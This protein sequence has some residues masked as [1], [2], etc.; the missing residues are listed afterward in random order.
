MGEVADLLVRRKGIRRVLC[1]A[2]VGEDLLF[3]VRTT[4][5][6]ENACQ[7]VVETTDQLGSG[8][9]HDRRAGG[10]IPGVVR[11]GTISQTLEKEI[12]TRWLQACQ[13]TD[14]PPKQLISRRDIVDNL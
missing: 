3:S 13:V 7:L 4:K 9:G 14:Q 6:A 2:A 12:V 8:G 11:D 5:D 10:K 1:A